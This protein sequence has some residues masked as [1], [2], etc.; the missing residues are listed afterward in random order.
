MTKKNERNE[1]DGGR[2]AKRNGRQQRRK[3]SLIKRTRQVSG[4]VVSL[5]SGGE[6]F[7]QYM[8]YY[9]MEMLWMDGGGENHWTVG[10]TVSRD[11]GGRRIIAKVGITI[12]L[13]LEKKGGHHCYL[14]RIRQKPVTLI[15]AA[16]ACCVTP[17][18]AVASV[19]TL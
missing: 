6:S 8:V 17:Q 7:S 1:G 3:A 9:P 16:C 5:E 4:I 11:F 15:V 14:P 2:W 19:E 13:F 18:C 12:A 10:R